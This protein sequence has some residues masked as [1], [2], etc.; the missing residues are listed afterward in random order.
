MYQLANPLPGAR[1]KVPVLDVKLQAPGIQGEMKTERIVLCEST[2]ITEFLANIDDNHQLLPQSPKKR[3]KIRLFVD[4]CGSTFNSYVAF[5][6]VQ[7]EEQLQ[8][9]YDQ[10]QDKM[11]LLD[12]FLAA[13]SQHQTPKGPFLLGQQFT[14]AEIHLAPFVQ[15]CCEQLPPPY[16]PLS[17]CEQRGLFQNHLQPWMQA[18]L[19]R[20]SV[21][22]TA[23][24]QE[25]KVRQEKMTN[26]LGRIQ[27]S[28]ST[29]K[30][31]LR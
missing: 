11:M 5:L 2:V 1:P 12:A 31:R 6:R 27:K 15:R 13:S 4:L 26:R 23:S 21:V 18:L 28:K 25:M 20:D 9:E 14:L 22:A 17:I 19:E 3:A 30:S 10:L 24:F 7:N 16:D 8:T 29:P